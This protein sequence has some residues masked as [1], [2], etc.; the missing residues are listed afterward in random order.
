[1]VGWLLKEDNVKKIK[2]NATNTYAHNIY[3]Q[4]IHNILFFFFEIGS[5]G[6]ALTDLK[7]RLALL[8]RS[9]C[10]CLPST[11]IKGMCHH[12]WLIQLLLIT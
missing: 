6:V 11:G 1:M 8:Q 7:T 4:Y 3:T 2:Q 10:L 5:Q 12:L 9:T